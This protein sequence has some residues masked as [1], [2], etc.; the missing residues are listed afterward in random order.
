MNVIRI[1]YIELCTQCRI[2]MTKCLYVN[3]MYI[4]NIACLLNAPSSR[5]Q[6]N[7]EYNLSQYISAA[8]NKLEAKW[9]AKRHPRDKIAAAV[10]IQYTG[11]C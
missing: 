5:K 3:Y 4:Y 11:P 8:S 1:K 6:D 7:S 2:F 9:Q 10:C